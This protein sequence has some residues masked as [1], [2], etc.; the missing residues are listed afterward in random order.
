VVVNRYWS[1][2]SLLV[3]KD[4][5]NTWSFVDTGSFNYA[6]G[7]DGRNY[8]RT[9]F[10]NNR[11]LFPLFDS[12][13]TSADGLSWQTT[14]VTN[15]PAGFTMAAISNYDTRIQKFMGVQQTGS[16][17]T[18]KTITAAVSADGIAWAFLAS[19]IPTTNAALFSGSSI[20]EGFL[21]V[22]GGTPAEVW[23]ST[24]EGQTWSRASGPWENPGVAGVAFSA[25]PSTLRRN[26][27]ENLLG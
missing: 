21:V 18:S 8:E 17:A 11:F 22:S 13:R 5:G 16:N 14:A 20:G 9:I 15:R 12:V 25:S 10:G 1:P 7:T 19:Q 2:G 24:N 3:S 6:P 23:V 4:L 27:H 26:S